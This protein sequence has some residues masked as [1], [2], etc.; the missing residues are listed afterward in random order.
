MQIEFTT[1]NCRAYW[2]LL[3]VA[4]RHFG[5]D[6]SGQPLSSL[7][8]AAIVANKSR[9]A[10]KE[11]VCSRISNCIRECSNFK[12]CIGSKGSQLRWNDF[13]VEACSFSLLRGGSTTSSVGVSWW[14]RQKLNVQKNAQMGLTCTYYGLHT[15]LF[16]VALMEVCDTTEEL[17]N[18]PCGVKL[19]CL[20]LFPRPGGHFQ[21]P[22]ASQYGREVLKVLGKVE[23]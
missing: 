8:D 2:I 23:I 6:H 20:Q 16:A 21:S 13:K 17:L 18:G 3:K 11:G 15:L 4:W 19:F 10:K 7:Q 1:D 12:G 14:I 9:Q 22:L 5:F